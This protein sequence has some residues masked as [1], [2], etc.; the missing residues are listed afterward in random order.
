[1]KYIVPD[2]VIERTDK[3]PHDFSCLETGKR[4]S[5]FEKAFFGSSIL[6]K[7]L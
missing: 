2:E 7:L 3:C 4:H 1:M 5:G 6:F